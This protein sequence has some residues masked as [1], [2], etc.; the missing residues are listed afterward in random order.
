L[1]WQQSYRFW[2]EHQ[3]QQL[4]DEDVTT[5]SFEQLFMTERVRQ[6]QVTY[7]LRCRELRK[8]LSA[9]EK[10]TIVQA[11]R[12]QFLLQETHCEHMLRGQLYKDQS[13]QWQN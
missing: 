13:H 3:C 10:E 1:S 12:M 8:K 5:Q 11:W 9:H 7:L 2:T 4:N 6:H